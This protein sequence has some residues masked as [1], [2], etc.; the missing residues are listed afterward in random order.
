MTTEIV[1]SLDDLEP[2]QVDELAL[3]QVQQH[4]CE[5]LVDYRRSTTVYRLPSVACAKEAKKGS[6][7]MAASEVRKLLA[8]APRETVVYWLVELSVITALRQGDDLEQELRLDAYERRLRQY[9]ADVVRY[10]TVQHSWRFWPT[11]AEMEEVCRKRTAPRL[12]MLAALQDEPN[13]I[14]PEC[15]APTQKE[16]A[17]VAA[18]VHKLYPELGSARRT[19]TNRCN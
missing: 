3:W 12:S 4:G 13:N 8:P 19:G 7:A 9:P 18:Y 17:R 2:Q 5:L 1:G 10:V 15:L 11:W 16:K 14:I 6:R